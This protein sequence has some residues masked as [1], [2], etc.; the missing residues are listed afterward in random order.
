MII[1]DLIITLGY[2]ALV[3]LVVGTLAYLAPKAL[4]FVKSFVKWNLHR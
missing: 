3:T 2:I 4:N 1:A